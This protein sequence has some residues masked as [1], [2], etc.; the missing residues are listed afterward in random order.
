MAVISAMLRDYPQADGVVVW[1]A[2]TEELCE[3]AAEEF[4][5]AWNILGDRP[6]SVFRHFGP[7]RSDLDSVRGGFLIGGLQLLYRD[8][9]NQQNAFLSLGR[10]TAMVV[11]D[12]AHQA[13]APSYNH[14][15]NLFAPDLQRMPILGLSA[16]P[17]RG[18][19]DA[20]EDL[21]LAE[22]F[23]WHKVTLQVEGFANPIDF[24]QQEGY[25]AQ[26]EY[27]PIPYAPGNN[28]ELTPDELEQ[29]R[30][31]LDLPDAVIQRLALDE[32]RNLLILTTVLREASQPDSRILVFACSVEHAKLIANLLRIKELKAECVTA[33]TP[34]DKRRQILEA[35]RRGEDVQIVTNYGVLTTGFDAPRTN[36]AVI[37]RPTRSVVLYAQMVG[38]AARGP[39]SGGN[40]RAR[41]ITVV[42]Q[43][44]GFRSIG[45]A[46]MFWDDIW[47]NQ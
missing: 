6:V 33:D 44:P 18:W 5:R 15:L 38:R 28:F 22:F 14:L 29:L 12:E 17:G 8:S 40:E 7:Y 9:L 46:F 30:S 41:V 2:H 35:F 47:T 16:T 23:A 42:D 34:A 37:T 39:R 11:M 21:R 27:I 13:L 19:L 26:V 43:I 4:E 45:E 31:D 24:L 36:V 3:Q 10:R 25:L 1:L 32:Q 20:E